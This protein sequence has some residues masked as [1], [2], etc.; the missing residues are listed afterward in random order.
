MVWALHQES[1]HPGVP[2]PPLL[3]LLP[4]RVLHVDAARPH[5][6]VVWV[7][8]DHLGD[9]IPQDI[10]GRHG[11]RDPGLGHGEL[12]DDRGRPALL[13]GQLRELAPVVL[14]KGHDGHGGVPLCRLLHDDHRCHECRLLPCEG[15]RESDLEVPALCSDRTC[16]GIVL[17]LA[18]DRLRPRAVGEPPHADPLQQLAHQ[19]PVDCEALRGAL[20]LFLHSLHRAVQ[21]S[22]LRGNPQRRCPQGLREAALAPRCDHFTERVPAWCDPGFGVGV[23]QG[24]LVHRARGGLHQR[25]LPRRVYG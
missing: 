1:Q 8:P 7:R 2:G 15:D 12:P 16:Q 6:R 11:S 21:V 9:H 25:L 3:D 23:P 13:R 20:P 5:A 18:E 24:L 14:A 17:A 4:P 19:E 22:N 10:E